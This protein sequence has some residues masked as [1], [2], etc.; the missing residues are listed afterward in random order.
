MIA[1]EMQH[2][3]IDFK[4]IT[5]DDR[6]LILSYLKQD[7]FMISDIS[8]GNLFIWRLA[9][10]I[11]FAIIYECLVIKTTYIDKNPF[12]FFPI[13]AGNK[14]SCIEILSQYCDDLD[15]LLEFRSLEEKSISILREIF[16]DIKPLLNRDRSDYIYLTK[17]LI[18]LSGRKYHRKKNHLNRFFE[19]YRGF[20]FEKIDSN[21]LQELQDTWHLWS[22]DHIDSGLIA[23]SKGIVSVLQNYCAL[24][25]RGGLLRFDSRIIA[26]SFG[27]VISSELC[28][29]HIEKADIA[30]RGAY[31]A[32]NHQLLSHC[33]ADIKY[34]NREEDLGIEGLRKAKMSYNPHI[35]LDKYEL[36]IYS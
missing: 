7:S 34:V 3:R 21:N 17:N 22:Q 10:K 35:I 18:E 25:F 1:D 28:V 23:E 26:F 24:G 31:Q 13:G 16:G 27:E 5:L 2:T 36:I 20:S 29:I 9:R 19:E 12:F 14:H 11:E 32:I 6:E 4:D 30:Y 8:F 15:I 33:F